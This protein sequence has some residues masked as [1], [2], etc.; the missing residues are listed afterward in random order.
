MLQLSIKLLTT[1][2]VVLVSSCTAYSN[3]EIAHSMDTYKECKYEP[4]VLPQL[5]NIPHV[6]STTMM[7]H[8]K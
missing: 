2:I 4:Y 3:N 8:C 1:C 6:S 5:L 7:L